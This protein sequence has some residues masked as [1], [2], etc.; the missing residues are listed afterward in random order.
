MAV[1]NSAPPR[2]PRRS[3]ACRERTWRSWRE[4]V[5]QGLVYESAVLQRMRRRPVTPPYQVL[6]WTNRAVYRLDWMPRRSVLTCW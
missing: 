6:A 2:T 5:Q 3:L 1:D 4:S